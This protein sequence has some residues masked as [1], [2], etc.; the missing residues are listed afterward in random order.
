MPP[1]VR[2]A[3]CLELVEGQDPTIL[4]GAYTKDMSARDDDHA[5]EMRR[6]FVQMVQPMGRDSL[7][8][9]VTFRVAHNAVLSLV[10]NLAPDALY[11]PVFDFPDTDGQVEAPTIK[12]EFKSRLGGPGASTVASPPVL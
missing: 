5:G 8:Q 1:V 6:P 9:D 10:S 12:V 11:E 4:V 2:R 3:V 7:G